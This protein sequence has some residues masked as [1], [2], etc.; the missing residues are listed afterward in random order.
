ME[1]HLEWLGLVSSFLWAVAFIVAVIP[2]N[3]LGSFAFN[4]WR[5]LC[6]SLILGSAALCTGGYGNISAHQVILM[7]LSGAVGICIGDVALF[8][9]FNRLGPRLSGI[10]FTTHAFFSVAIG[11]LFF[12]ETLTLPRTAGIFLIFLGVSVTL[13]FSEEKKKNSTFAASSIPVG[14]AVF[15]GIF[16]GFCQASGLAIAKPVVEA[17]IS[18]VAAS[19]VRMFCAFIIHMLMLHRTCSHFLLLQPGHDPAD[20][21]GILPPQA[22]AVL[23][24]CSCCRC[25]RHRG[26]FQLEI[27]SFE[28]CSGAFSPSCRRW[29]RS[30]PD[31]SAGSSRECF[32][33]WM[34]RQS[35]LKG[36]LLFSVSHP[37]Q[38]IFR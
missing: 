35:A 32:L 20:Y 15:L 24:V 14:I 10:L 33:L 36:P 34:H 6:S 2:V 11:M 19:S 9:C 18:P 25:S 37:L 31:L 22:A 21:V 23:L 1:L 4:R 29:I 38:L 26:D 5:M 17:G 28:A 8:A 13:Y 12:N 16:A 3:R 30:V 7:C 27:N